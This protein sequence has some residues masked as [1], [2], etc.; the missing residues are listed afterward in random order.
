MRTSSAIILAIVVGAT[1]AASRMA[2]AGDDCL[3]APNAGAPPGSHWYYRLDRATHRKCWYVG[4]QGTKVR[5]AAATPPASARAPVALAPGTQGPGVAPA[6]DMPSPASAPAP[7]A[8]FASRWPDAATPGSTPGLFDPGAG[9]AGPAAGAA[10]TA[11]MPE[12]IAARPVTTST[13][14]APPPGTSSRGEPAPPPATPAVADERPSLPAA[15]AGVAVLLAVV[16]TIL[17]RA[18]RRAVRNPD[19][20]AARNPGAPHFPRLKAGVMRATTD[21]ADA[22]LQ[23]EIDPMPAEPTPGP[24]VEQSLRQLLQ[25]WE[26]RAA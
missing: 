11:G 24:D 18:G 15:L 3:A 6:V 22:T 1:A 16:G 2:P 19:E 9:A 26:P 8:A 14:R 13:E 12:R 4:A 25:A 5:R 10:P 21:I 7:D 23:P 20:R 17:V